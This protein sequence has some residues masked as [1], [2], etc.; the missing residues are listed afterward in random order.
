MSFALAIMYGSLGSPVPPEYVPEAIATEANA[1]AYSENITYETGNF[2]HLT[3]SDNDLVYYNSFDDDSTAVTYDL[4]GSNNGVITN[5]TKSSS[6]VYG[7]CMN[8]DGISDYITAKSVISTLSLNSNQEARFLAFFNRIIVLL[9]FFAVLGVAWAEELTIEIT[10]GVEGALPIA[11]LPFGTQGPVTE[12]IAAIVGEAN[13]WVKIVPNDKASTIRDLT[14][15]AV[16]GTLSVPV[17]R[18]RKMNIGP[19]YLALF[20]CGDQLLWGAAE[21]VRRVLRIVLKYAK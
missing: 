13:E 9:S 3:V 12:D 4:A 17:G 20:T 2:S 16:S 6:C 19:K 1:K 15:A 10:R 11:I 21:P 14:P 5:A 18:I 8:F 7:K